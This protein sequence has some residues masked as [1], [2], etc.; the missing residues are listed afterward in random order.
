MLCTFANSNTYVLVVTLRLILDFQL[1]WLYRY[2]YETQF[3]HVGKSRMSGSSK[4]ETNLENQHSKSSTDLDEPET[5]RNLFHSSHK[6]C[7]LTAS[8]LV[9]K[10]ATLQE[11]E[12]KVEA[13]FSNGLDELTTADRCD[14]L[15]FVLRGMTSLRRLYMLLLEP[16]LKHY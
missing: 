6:L 11:G 13:P 4:Y 2:T 15:E 1:V 16:N 14:C 7:R 8:R 3:S 9:S 5:L 12:P 10:A